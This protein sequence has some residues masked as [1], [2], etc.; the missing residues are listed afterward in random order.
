M[1]DR[2]VLILSFEEAVFIGEALANAAARVAGR[3]DGLA[4]AQEI[5][6]LVPDYTDGADVED[7]RATLE[8]LLRFTEDSSCP[9][10]PGRIR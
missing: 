6:A 7:A 4:D 1:T 2:P 9:P 10:I 8:L 5:R 3:N